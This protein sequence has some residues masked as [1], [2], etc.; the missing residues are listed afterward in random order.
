MPFSERGRDHPC[1]LFS[2]DKCGV[3]FRGSQCLRSLAQWRNGAATN[4]TSTKT[5]QKN[6][7]VERVHTYHTNLLGMGL[8]SFFVIY[9]A[10][11]IFDSFVVRNI[12]KKVLFSRAK[13]CALKMKKELIV[14]GSPHLDLRTG[15]VISF[16]TEKT[17]GPVYGC[18][19]T[20]VDIQGCT[21]CDNSYTGDVLDYL[22]TREPKS[23]VFFSSGVLEFTNCFQQIKKEIERTCVANFTDYYSPWNLSWYVYGCSN[24]NNCGLLKGLPRRVFWTDP[25]KNL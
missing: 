1:T 19:D 16:L 15:G 8:S 4:F 5:P 21:G 13:L 22:K 17:I 24:N 12:K 14:V 6:V 9:I 2:L 3:F 10:C 11:C 23:C 20:C 25:F 18:G 7:C